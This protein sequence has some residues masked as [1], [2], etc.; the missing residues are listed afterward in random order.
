MSSVILLPLL[1]SEFPKSAAG[2]TLHSV[3]TDDTGDNP[4]TLKLRLQ[5]DVYEN[6]LKGI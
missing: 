6:M 5:S 4:S 2:K 1:T 3:A